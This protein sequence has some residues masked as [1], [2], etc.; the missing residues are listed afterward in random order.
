MVGLHA[1]AP[2]FGGPMLA[3]GLSDAWA[4]EAGGDFSDAWRM[5]WGGARY[6]W[7]PRRHAKHYLAVDAQ[8]ALGAGAGGELWG[9]DG[10]ESDGRR[11][12]E[13]FAGGGLLGAGVAGHFSF[14]SVFGRARAQVTKATNIPTTGW[15]TVGG[16]IQ[17]RIART[18]DLY[19]Q[20]GPSGYRN[21]IDDA[22]GTFTEAGV[23]VRI[24]TWPWRQRWR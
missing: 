5:G 13:R 4:I 14:F 17:F 15:W 10:E 1:P 18:V 11:A 3:Y 20:S 7:A 19:A 6:T 9:N 23:A 2:S 16:G 22:W 24:P 8:A 21:S 12:F